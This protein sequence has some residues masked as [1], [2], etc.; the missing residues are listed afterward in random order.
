VET[1]GLLIVL[2]GPSGAGKGTLCKLLREEMPELEYSVSVTT[3]A[4]RAGEKEGVNYYYIDKE[5]FEQMIVNNELL[6]WAKVY[7]NYYGTPK[8]QVLE[9]LRQGKD[10]ILE[11]DIQG[12]M[13]IKKQYP[14]GV[15]IFIVPPSIQELENRITKRGTDSV[16]AIKK[17]LSCACE[18]LSYVTEYDYVIVNDTV[19]NA[20]EKLKAVI[21]AERCRPQRK[22]MEG[23]CE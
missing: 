8:K 7:D 22:K 18:E 17:R 4:P 1:S 6:E 11:I 15:F 9:H 13:N 2:S 21:I 20:I 12:A 19:E 5:T 10:I 23:F 16:E 3:R 14:K